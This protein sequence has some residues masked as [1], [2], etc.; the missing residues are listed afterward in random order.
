MTVPAVDALYMPW[1]PVFAGVRG[2]L[3]AQIVINSVALRVDVDVIDGELSAPM[4]LLERGGLSLLAGSQAAAD[5]VAILEVRAT[6]LGTS[7]DQV[8]SI[9]ARA[10]RVLTGRGRAGF[11]QPLSV[12]G[13][14]VVDR[15][16]VLDALP[17]PTV[18][19]GWANA[20]LPVNLL[21]QPVTEPTS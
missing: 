6:F 9:R 12:A 2:L 8:D 5:D 1:R 18:G 17:R 15:R 14:V 10:L 11:F 20:V 13:M 19:G 3:Q 7:I 4:C 21:L 16:R